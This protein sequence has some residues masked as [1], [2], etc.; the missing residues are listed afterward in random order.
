[1]SKRGLFSARARERERAVVLLIFL[2]NQP[3]QNLSKYDCCRSHCCFAIQKN[4]AGVITPDSFFF[5]LFHDIHFPPFYPQKSPLERT[6]NETKHIARRQRHHY[7]QRNISR[8]QRLILRR[9]TYPNNTKL[10]LKGSIAAKFL[11]RLRFGHEFYPIFPSPPFNLLRSHS[12]F[13]MH[14]KC[15]ILQTYVHVSIGEK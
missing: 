6:I 12:Q 1:M 8:N 15:G 2:E 9:S 5:V 13:H 3:I 14:V 10:F 7:T 11:V 4:Y